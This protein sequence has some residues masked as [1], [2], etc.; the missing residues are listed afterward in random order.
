M[1]SITFKGLGL[2]GRV[3][4]SRGSGVHSRVWGFRG[5]E[6]FRVWDGLGLMGFTGLRVQEF[7]V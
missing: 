2:Q 1:G 4:A 3:L 7:K 6:W 5:L